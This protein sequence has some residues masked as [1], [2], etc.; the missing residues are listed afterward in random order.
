MRG[1]LMEVS[2]RLEKWSHIKVQV[3]WSGAD[4]HD[5]L[6]ALT[7]QAVCT[8]YLNDL[9]YSEAFLVEGY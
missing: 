2:Q 3:R 9:S 1:A 4:L 8:K 6:S 5:L 7:W